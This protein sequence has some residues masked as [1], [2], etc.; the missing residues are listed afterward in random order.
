M[1]KPLDRDVIA[2]AMQRAA[3]VAVHGTREEQSGKFM[4]ERYLDAKSDAPAAVKA[5]RS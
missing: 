5:R 1:N 4:P 2:K 3:W